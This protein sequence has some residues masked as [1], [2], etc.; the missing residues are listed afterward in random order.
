MQKDFDNWYYANTHQDAVEALVDEHYV[1]SGNAAPADDDGLQL[2]LI[3][4]TLAPSSYK[5]AATSKMSFE[6][7]FAQLE[8][9]LIARL[10]ADQSFCKKSARFGECSFCKHH[11]DALDRE[12]A[13]AS[14]QLVA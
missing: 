7:L 9:K 12:Q 1:K 13:A 11:R 10:R 3:G 14:V 6:Q 2:V 5:V 8:E 4:H